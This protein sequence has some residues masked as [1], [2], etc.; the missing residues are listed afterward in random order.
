MQSATSLFLM[1]VLL[2][3]P[4]VCRW[5]GHAACSG[6]GKTSIAAD[7]PHCCPSSQEPGPD[8]PTDD[9]GP[10]TDCIC[11][12]AVCAPGDATP[13]IE[14]EQPTGWL[15]EFAVTAAVEATAGNLASFDEIAGAAP[16][17]SGRAMRLLMASLRF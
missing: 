9:R 1:A 17:L 7:C 2:A 5:Q 13:A 8:R 15:D 3:C 14:V 12:G 10:P 6:G 11:N 16:P 4:H